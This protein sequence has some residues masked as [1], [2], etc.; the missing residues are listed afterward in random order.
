MVSVTL[1]YDQDAN[2]WAAWLPGVAAYGQGD[3]SQ[4]ALQSLR[5]A[6]TL[7]IEETGQETFLEHLDPPQQSLTLPL[8]DLVRET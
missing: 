1:S 5:E 4:D 6:L 2:Q 8:S 3:T 7:Y